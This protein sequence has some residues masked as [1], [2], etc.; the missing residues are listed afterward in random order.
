MP[1]YAVNIADLTSHSVFALALGPYLTREQIAAEPDML[2]GLAAR[3]NRAAPLAQ[4]AAL[5]EIMRGLPGG[6]KHQLRIYQRIGA[7]WERVEQIT[8]GCR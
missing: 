2:D 1:E 7:R 8:E 5:V 3:V 6:K 4:F